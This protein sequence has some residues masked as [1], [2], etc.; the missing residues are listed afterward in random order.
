MSIWCSWESVGW[1]DW[2]ER[3]GFVRGEVRTFAEGFSNH[4]PDSTGSHELPANVGVDHIAP[5]CVPGH[6]EGEPDNHV[7]Y[8]C[9]GCG[10][11]HDYPDAGRWL[12]LGIYARDALSWWTDDGEDKPKHTGPV[13]QRVVMDEAAVRA[14]RDDLTKWLELPKVQPIEEP[15]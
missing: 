2:A 7:D 3:P 12:R 14:L 10:E 13:A 1:D 6:N 4:H 5:W 8:R 11:R 15:T 9:T